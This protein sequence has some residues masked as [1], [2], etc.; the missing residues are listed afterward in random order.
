MSYKIVIVTI[1]AALVFQTLRDDR[2]LHLEIAHDSPQWLKDLARQLQ[3]YYTNTIMKE[4]AGIRA[5]VEWTQSYRSI[6]IY[7][8][9]KDAFATL[10]D[11]AGMDPIRLGHLSL[12]AA[13]LFLV[14]LLLTTPLQTP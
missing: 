3:A 10:G 8:L 13:L 2:E 11:P 7:R 4:S 1:V 12:W 9:L 6:H 14:Y 5:I